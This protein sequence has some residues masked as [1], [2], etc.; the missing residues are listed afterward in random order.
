VST[1][2]TLNRR[3]FAKAIVIGAG[4]AAASALLAAPPRKIKIGYTCL[5]WNAAPRTPENLEGALKD[6]STLGFYKFETFAEVLESW[7]Q[8]GELGTLIGRY[9]VPL[10][11]GYQTVNVTDQDKKRDNLDMVTRLAKVIKKHNGTFMVLAANGVKRSEYNFQENRKNIVD[12]LNDYAKAA[13]DA[14]LGCGF[15]QHTGTAIESKEETYTLMES[16]DTRH[17]KFAP[18]VGQ[19][20]KGGVDAL[21]VVKDFLPIVKHMHL[22]DFAGGQAFAGYCPLGQGKVDIAGIL[23]TLEKANSDANIMV[24]L[25]GSK[26]QPLTPLETAQISKAYLVKLG[27][28]FRA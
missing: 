2:A 19:L 4:G 8:K 13:N 14:G 1:K 15:H 17:L 23:D 3:D 7:D 20:Q 21:Q 9:G 10:T 26:D 25:D 24:E 12:S 16:V 6:L 5:I 11:S 18:D 27:Y 28:K 22:K